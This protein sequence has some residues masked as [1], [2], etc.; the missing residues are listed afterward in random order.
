MRQAC[1]IS[2]NRLRNSDVRDIPYLLIPTPIFCYE[3]CALLMAHNHYT[4]YLHVRVSNGTATNVLPENVVQTAPSLY[5]VPPGEDEELVEGG[6]SYYSYPPGPSTNQLYDLPPVPELNTAQFGR[7]TEELISTEERYL[8]D[9]LLAKKLFR[10]NL[11]TLPYRKEVESIFQHWDELIEVSRKMYLGLKNCTSP[12]HVFISEIDSL[13]VF[14]AFC[15]HQQTAL[16]TL[17]QL[18][19]RPDAQRLYQKCAASTAARGMSLS[20]FLLTPLGRITRFCR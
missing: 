20:T 10:E 4:C 7:L 17:N 14:V 16:D 9:L 15:S 19:T 12:G 5:E 2:K 13:A 8:G 3:W 11:V 1:M 6:S 18:L